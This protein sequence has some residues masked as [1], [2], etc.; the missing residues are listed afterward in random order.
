MAT[1]SGGGN[2][3]KKIDELVHSIEILVDV[4]EKRGRANRASSMYH[5][6]AMSDKNNFLRD[7]SSFNITDFNKTIDDFVKGL[8]DTLTD[9]QRELKNTEKI[10]NDT[11]RFNAL[12]AKEQK[13]ILNKRDK[14][15]QKTK[16]LD[17]AINRYNTSPSEREKLFSHQRKK[18]ISK[19]KAEYAS[20][21]E[22][23]KRKYGSEQGY[24]KNRTEYNNYIKE[25][26]HYSNINI[27]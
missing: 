18:E 12:S 22:A 4:V 19:L 7:R 8:K 21:S 17:A 24:I 26:Y 2:I 14:L 27:F 20:F 1:N 5:V 25:Y 9:F 16:N 6:S 23:E 3:D 11:S 15:Q 13:E 10:I